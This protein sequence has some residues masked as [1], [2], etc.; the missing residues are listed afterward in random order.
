[1]TSDSR[2]S[3]TNNRCIPSVICGFWIHNEEYSDQQNHPVWGSQW[4]LILYKNYY[5]S[6]LPSIRTGAVCNPRT[7]SFSFDHHFIIQNQIIW[8][9][10]GTIPTQSLQF[11]FRSHFNMDDFLLFCIFWNSDNLGFSSYLGFISSIPV[12]P[13]HLISM[14]SAGSFSSNLVS[15]PPPKILTYLL[16]NPGRNWTVEWLTSSRERPRWFSALHACHAKW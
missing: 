5:K 10:I 14:I 3:S 6:L 9:C 2:T 12:E 11:S 1:M 15:S 4:E 7:Y 8:T 16:L 13:S